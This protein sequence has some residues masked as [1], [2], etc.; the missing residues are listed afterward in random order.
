ME[1]LRKGGKAT[2]QSGGT[3]ALKSP[4]RGE[5][6]KMSKMRRRLNYTRGPARAAGGAPNCNDDT[7]SSSPLAASLQSC[8]LLVDSGQAPRAPETGGGR[9]HPHEITIL[10]SSKAAEDY[11]HKEMEPHHDTIWDECLPEVERALMMRPSEWSRHVGTLVK[12]KEKTHKQEVK[13]IMSHGLSHRFKLSLAK[14]HRFCF[15]VNYELRVVY[16]VGLR[17][18]EGCWNIGKK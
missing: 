18:H 5:V 17:H 6:H 12:P 10:W 14:K 3:A 9:R 1:A 8:G 13:D 15:H 4:R 7:K 2:L 16:V 11:A